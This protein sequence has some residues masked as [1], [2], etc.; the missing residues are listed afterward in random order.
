MQNENLRNYLLAMLT[1]ECDL[2]ENITK[3]GLTEFNQGRLMEINYL[4]D[5]IINFENIPVNQTW[6]PET[7]KRKFKLF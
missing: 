2:I 3:G 4:L 5:L 6:Q 7:K 1:R